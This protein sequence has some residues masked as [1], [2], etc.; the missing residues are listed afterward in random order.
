[1]ASVAREGACERW[2]EDGRGSSKVGGGQV[3]QGL[4]SPGW[5]L[6]FILSPFRVRCQSTDGKGQEL[7]QGDWSGGL[8][9]GLGGRGGG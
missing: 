5:N 1:M 9:R 7:K 3:M 4:L 8:C 2:E 6:D